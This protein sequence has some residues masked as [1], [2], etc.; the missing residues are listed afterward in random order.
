MTTT[1]VPTPLQ[2]NAK[3][4]GYSFTRHAKD[5]A[6]KKGFS[7]DDVLKA[8]SEPEITYGN[9]MAQ[10]QDRHIRGDIVAIVDIV[11]RRIITVYENVKETEVRPDQVKS[12]SVNN[13]SR[14]AS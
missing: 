5:Q 1:R 10:G 9:G 2:M 14:F 4:L 8:A 7:L 13:K 3:R 6:F 12:G 11:D